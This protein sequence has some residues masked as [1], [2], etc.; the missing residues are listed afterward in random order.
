MPIPF[1]LE[2]RWTTG[3]AGATGTAGT[4]GTTGT[5]LGQ[6]GRLGHFGKLGHEGKLRLQDCWI[7]KPRNRLSL[8]NGTKPRNQ[9]EF[10]GQIVRT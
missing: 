6:L 10:R 2:F 3:T 5:A 7:E 1:T 8:Q 9:E 4:A